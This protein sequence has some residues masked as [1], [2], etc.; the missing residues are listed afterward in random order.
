MATYFMFGKYSAAA[1]PEIS[2]ERTKKAEDVVKQHGGAIESMHALLGEH[3][4]VLVVDLPGVHQAM[5]ASVALSRLTGISFS[6]SPAVEVA[7]FDELM[8]KS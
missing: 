3:D 8:H 2:V 4:L 6:T 7:Q 5:Q 1:L